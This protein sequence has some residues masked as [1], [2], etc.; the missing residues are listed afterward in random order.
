MIEVEIECAEPGWSEA[1]PN[2]EALARTA[3][4]EALGDAGFDPPVE[5]AVTLLLA[6]DA[7]LQD[8]NARFRQKDKPTNVL[9]FPAHPSAA[10]H[11]G[12][13]A[14]A[15]GVCVAEAK[16]QQKPLAHHLQHLC[17]HGALHLIG[18]DHEDEAE[19]EEMEALERLILARLNVPDPYA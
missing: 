10:P 11:L 19:A 13:L 3:V 8:L 18:F 9:S 17:V 6:D 12:D 1:L 2:V 16:E 4:V 5:G 7:A 15:F 14:L